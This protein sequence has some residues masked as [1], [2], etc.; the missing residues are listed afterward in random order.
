[1]VVCIISTRITA[2][3]NFHWLWSVQLPVHCRAVCFVYSSDTRESWCCSWGGGG[4]G[5]FTLCP[6]ASCSLVSSVRRAHCRWL[7]NNTG[8]SSEKP[9]DGPPLMSDWRES[10][11]MCGNV[12][13]CK[14]S[15][16]G[17]RSETRRLLVDREEAQTQGWKVKWIEDSGFAAKGRR[18]RPSSR[19]DLKT[20][21]VFKLN[22]HLLLL[23]TPFSHPPA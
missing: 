8:P 3:Y 23:P 6:N 11:L 12:A 17:K 13:V 1:M 14:W 9:P 5:S 10:E 15:E 19:Q 22:Q 16:R 2:I 4:G 18:E 20:S 7:A 21:C